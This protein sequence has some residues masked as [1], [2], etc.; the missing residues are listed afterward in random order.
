MSVKSCVGRGWASASSMIFMSVMQSHA[1]DFRLPRLFL[2]H[3]L[4][5][6][7]ELPL[8]VEQVH[9]LKTVMRRPDGTVLRLFNGR[10]GEWDGRLAFSG[11]K[12]GH[13]VIGKQI[14]PAMVRALR[15]HLVFALIKKD[16]MDFMIEK[17]VELGVSDLHPVLTQNT[18]IRDLN[19]VRME[20]Q[21]LEAAEQCERLDLPVLHPL[22]TLKEFLNSWPKTVPLLAALE[23]EDAALIGSAGATAATTGLLIG[24]EGGFSE[25]ERA[26][27]M[28]HDGVHAVTLGDQILRSET[29]AI[30]GLSVLSANFTK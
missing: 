10:E 12:E 19:T 27:L 23:R 22:L 9:Y 1:Y 25:D 28:K 13:I 21:A 16:R 11:K 5:A 24:P 3:P 14:R 8:S 6:G 4:S 30:F 18:V 20:K 2:D 29:A 15:L 7:A 17:A 26:L